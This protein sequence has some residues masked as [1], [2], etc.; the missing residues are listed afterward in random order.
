MISI[1]GINNYS[2]YP[3]SGLPVNFV[4]LYE[5]SKQV[6]L[7]KPKVPTQIEPQ[8]EGETRT[9]FCKELGKCGLTKGYSRANLTL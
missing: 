4:R 7:Q 8:T 1:Y 3:L 9:S 6:T 2:N 5:L